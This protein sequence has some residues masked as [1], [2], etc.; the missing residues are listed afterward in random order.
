MM[1]VAVPSPNRQTRLEAP[2]PP[3]I[4][5]EQLLAIADEVL[6]QMASEPARI[7]VDHTAIGMA[8]VAMGRVLM[9]DN[10]DRIILSIDAQFGQRRLVHLNVDQIDTASLRAVARYLD[11]LGREQP[12]DP[13]SLT[14]PIAPRTYRPMTVWKTSTVDAFAERRHAAVASLVAPVLDAGFAA[15]A[16]VGVSA[17][18]TG[19]V[20]KQGRRVAGHDTDAELVVTGWSN[21]GKAS[22]WAGQAAREWSTMDPAAVARRSIELTQRSANPVA[23]EPGRYTV[24]LDRPAVAQIVHAMGWAFDAEP[25]LVGGTPLFNRATKKSHLGDRIVD[26]RISLSSDPNDPDGGYLPFTWDGAPL[27][28]MTWIDHGIHTNLAFKQDFAA[29]IG[30]APSNYPP[31]ALRMQAVPST[32][33]MSVDEMIASCKLGIY[34]NRIS[35]VD[36]PSGDPVIGMMTGVT[37]GGCFLVRDGAIEKPIRNLRFLESP[38]LFLD[39]VEAIGASERSAFGYAPWAGGWPIDPTIVPPLKVRD[40]YFNALADNV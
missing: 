38:W 7:Y 4:S 35:H 36:G 34:V 8:R 15:S 10:G 21:D 32:A 30:Y 17:R 31:G 24:I 3:V 26:A 19:Y 39:R 25:T 23:F 40:F 33:L 37:S 1:R 5:P 6:G 16:F 18:S 9:Q 20:D 27:I 11:R 28:P 12:G 29:S 14:M 22:G 2:H 13:A